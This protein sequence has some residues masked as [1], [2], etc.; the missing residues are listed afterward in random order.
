MNLDELE[1]LEVL[2]FSA[3]PYLGSEGVAQNTAPSPQPAQSVAWDLVWAATPS[4]SSTHSVAF[5]FP[6]PDPAQA[7]AAHQLLERMIAAMKLTSEAAQ[8]F[9]DL[10]PLSATLAQRRPEWTVFLGPTAPIELDHPTLTT[11]AL[12]D[13][14]HQP[15]L[16]RPVW[17]ELQKILRTWEASS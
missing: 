13:I 1:Y 11:H 12:G 9:T 14:L 17:E 16:K 5:V 15:A 3:H 6:S 4:G 2:G 10:T 8:S 7:S